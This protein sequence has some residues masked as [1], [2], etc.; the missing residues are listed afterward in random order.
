ML[1]GISTSR[2]TGAVGHFEAMLRIG[3]KGYRTPAHRCLALAA[4]TLVACNV[5]LLAAVAGFR[6]LAFLLFLFLG[7]TF[8]GVLLGLLDP[9]AFSRLDLGGLLGRGAGIL[10]GLKQRFRLSLPG[11]FLARTAFF[12]LRLLPLLL[13]SLRVDV[14]PLPRAAAIELFLFLLC[15]LL[16]DVALDVGPLSAHL[17]VHSPRTA[18]R[19]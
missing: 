19:A 17:D 12:L 11:F 4:A 3:T 2:T 15:F 10:L 14:S 1:S 8:P 18:L 9:G 16:E 7:A 13:A 5:Q 6:R